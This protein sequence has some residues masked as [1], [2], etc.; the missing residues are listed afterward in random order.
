MKPWQANALNGIVL[1]AMGLWGAMGTT[2]PTAYIPVG[3]GA[4]FLLL[5]PPFKSENKIVAHI[6]V[7]LTFLLLIALGK[8]LGAAVE[9]GDNM[10][11]LRSIIMM[12]FNILAFATYIKSFVDARKARKE[13]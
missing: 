11:I 4:L 5:T 8:P 1:I 6:V 3:F 9:S 2:S 7:V 13:A 10:R 12:L